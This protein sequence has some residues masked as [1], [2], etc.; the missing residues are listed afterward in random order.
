MFIYQVFIFIFISIYQV[1]GYYNGDNFFLPK[2]KIG[3]IS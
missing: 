3:I 1:N 2:K